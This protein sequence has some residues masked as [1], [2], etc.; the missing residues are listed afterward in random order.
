MAYVDDILK[1]YAR[2]AKN[3]APRP[4]AGDVDIAPLV[5]ARIHRQGIVMRPALVFRLKRFGFGAALVGF[6]ALAVAGLNLSLAMMERAGALEFINFGPRGVPA[7]ASTLPLDYLAAALVF[8]IIGYALLRRTTLFAGL[9][10]LRLT[11]LYAVFILGLSMSFSLSPQVSD[12][13]L[14][15]NPDGHLIAGQITARLSQS[16]SPQSEAA[17]GRYGI[18]ENVAIIGRVTKSSPAEIVVET[19]A[20]TVVRLQGGRNNALFTEPFY[21]EGQ[22]VKAVG[23]MRDGVFIVSAADTMGPRGLDYF[24]TAIVP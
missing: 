5:M 20:H 12:A 1:A 22:I 9:S 11:A 3:Q 6:A 24:S 7:I 2:G 16:R 15:L 13:V 8:G 21:T 19:P 10:H 23:E 17:A 14:A 4:A 18:N